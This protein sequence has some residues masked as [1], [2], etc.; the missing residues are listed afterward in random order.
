[1]GEVELEWPEKLEWTDRW[2]AF[3]S[4][5]SRKSSEDEPGVLSTQSFLEEDDMGPLSPQLQATSSR[6]N[7]PLSSR[8]CSPGSLV[9]VPFFPYVPFFRTYGQLLAEEKWAPQPE[10][11]RDQGGNW[12]VREAQFWEDLEPPSGYFPYY[13]S[14]EENFPSLLRGGFQDP[15][16][17]KEVQAGCFCRKTVSIGSSCQRGSLLETSRT[18]EDIELSSFSEEAGG[19]PLDPKHLPIARSQ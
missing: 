19:L 13:R 7:E 6:A 10:V 4:Q 11:C 9:D 8:D 12:G 16:T 14:K 15:P 1:M 18:L 2:N 5:T 3:S 17:R